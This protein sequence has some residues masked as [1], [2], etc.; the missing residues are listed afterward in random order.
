[1]IS[2]KVFGRMEVAGLIVLIALLTTISI[3]TWNRSEDPD[4]EP[5]SLDWRF[6]TCCFEIIEIEPSIDLEDVQ[7]SILDL[8]GTVATWEDPSGELIE[9]RGS[10]ADVNFSQSGY[11]DAD[12]ICYNKY[13]SRNPVGPP[14]VSTNHTLCIVFMDV[15]SDGEISSGDVI[16][17]RSVDNGGAADDDFSLRLKTSRG[18]LGELL[19]PPGF[20]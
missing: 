19:L 2:L 1:M 20:R 10:L 4:P 13:Y 15:N 6:S 14:P 17:V 8:N 12:E 7:W 16:W 3:Q 11:D 5:Y 9:M 18:L